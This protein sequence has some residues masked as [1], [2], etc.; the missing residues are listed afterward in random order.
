MRIPKIS[1]LLRTNVTSRCT[2]VQLR[3]PC[4]SVCAFCTTFDPS[5]GGLKSSTDRKTQKKNAE[6]GSFSKNAKLKHPYSEHKLNIQYK[7]DFKSARLTGKILPY[8]FPLL[9]AEFRNN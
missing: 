6:K 7:E 8:H 1:V 5:F 2:Y 4:G 9:T 3:G